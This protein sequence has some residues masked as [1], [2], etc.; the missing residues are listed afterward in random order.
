MQQGTETRTLSPVPDY[1]PEIDPVIARLKR[2]RSPRTPIKV[3]VV[4]AIFTVLAVV[5]WYGRSVY[6]TR[7]AEAEE[8]KARAAA[9]AEA[10]RPP[11]ITPFQRVER[12]CAE[13]L[14]G[15]EFAGL[16]RIDAA[17]GRFFVL[18]TAEP[19][20]SVTAV[21]KRFRTSAAIEAAAGGEILELAKRRHTEQYR[22]RQLWVGDEIRLLVPLPP[23]VANSE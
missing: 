4:I 9:E 22:G 17:D 15:T 3:L 2:R 19:G 14:R 13:N 18:Y 16:P 6:N 5:V 23:A 8:A 1:D 10:S 11:T 12:W 7:L 21:V 20:D